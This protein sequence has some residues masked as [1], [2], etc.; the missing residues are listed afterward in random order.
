MHYMMPCLNDLG[1]GMH[2]NKLNAYHFDG[3]S[4]N[5][6]V[7]MIHYVSFFVTQNSPK[8]RI[9]Y[10][11]LGYYDSLIYVNAINMLK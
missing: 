6:G 1:T 3:K 10:F 11:Q 2:R 5:L 8:S 4:W 9:I 7:L